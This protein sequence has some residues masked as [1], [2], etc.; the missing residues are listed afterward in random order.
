MKKQ[1]LA[2]AVAGLF[3]VPAVAQITVS[4]NIDVTATRSNE[5]SQ[6]ASGGTTPYSVVEQKNT[7][8]GLGAGIDDASTTGWAT[9][10]LIF[11][12]TEDLGGGLKATARFSQ[13][14]SGNTLGVQRDRYVDVAGGFGS[15]RLGR[16]NGFIGNFNNFSG[17][18]T[19]AQGGE[20]N[21]FTTGGGRLFGS[22]I[23]G[24][25]FE[26]NSG[27][28]Q[29]TSPSFS[30]FTVSAAYADNSSDTTST[31]NRLTES[32]MQTIGAEYKAGPLTVAFASGERKNKTAGVAAVKGRAFFYNGTV[33]AT[34]EQSTGATTT[35]GDAVGATTGY[36]LLQGSVTPNGGNGVLAGLVT[37]AG[38]TEQG[39]IDATH[40][41]DWIG[42]SYNLGPA[43]IMASHAL[44]KS[45][46]NTTAVGSA[47]AQLNDAK[48]TS[49]GL[50]VP[51]GATTLR[52]STYQGK[53]ERGTATTDDVKIEGYQ[54]GVTYNLSK[55]TYLYGVVGESDVK[56]DGST[57][58]AH[59]RTEK[60]NSI[61]VVHTF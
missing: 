17:A 28:I 48:L 45:I 58:T 51:L 16:F 53:D 55:R 35:V 54:L 23:T 52:A 19:T 41:F 18:G 8:S 60:S 7:G 61:G 2:T 56:R 39:A 1:L 12:A 30:G 22:G 6:T 4:G 21:S 27:Q 49:V 5:I 46:S 42:A 10:E 24:G 33:N 13:N 32:K 37:V 15:V 34:M 20:L 57:S 3:A 31:A 25:N 50:M 40:D 47:Q 26:R 44:R 59:T 29:Y 38:A 9:S 43:T 11:Q 36:S 14:I